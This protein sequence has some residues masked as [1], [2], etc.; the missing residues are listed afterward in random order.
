MRCGLSGVDRI[1]IVPPIVLDSHHPS[2]N[3]FFS[4]GHHRSCEP[5]SVVSG[6][7]LASSALTDDFGGD[8]PNVSA[9]RCANLAAIPFGG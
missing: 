6:H 2:T 7:S 3:F 5:R 8:Y 9:S 4:S 1:Y